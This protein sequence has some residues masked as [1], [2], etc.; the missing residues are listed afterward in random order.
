[1]TDRAAMLG[2]DLKRAGRHQRLLGRRRPTTA[3]SCPCAERRD[4]T[5]ARGH[6]AAAP[7]SPVHLSR[8]CVGSQISR[9][10]S[11][12]APQARARAETLVVERRS[13]D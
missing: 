6:D 4:I 9:P 7:R 5:A 2:D 1:M 13:N 8:S 3:S 12:L 10:S 11:T